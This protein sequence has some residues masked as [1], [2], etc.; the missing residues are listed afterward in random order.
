MSDASKK[1]SDKS[2]NVSSDKSKNL[3]SEK[4]KALKHGKNIQATA[5]IEEV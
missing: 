4:S 5:T 1:L 3:Q 2:K